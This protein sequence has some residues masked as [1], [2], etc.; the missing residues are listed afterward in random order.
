MADQI[1][2]FDEQRLK[3]RPATLS[4]DDI[5]AVERAICVELGIT[6]S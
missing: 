5:C 1:A 4:H 6:P 3:S 2:T